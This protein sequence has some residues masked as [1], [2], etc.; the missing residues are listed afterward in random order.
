MQKPIAYANNTFSLEADSMAQI[1]K[2]QIAESTLAYI[3]PGAKCAKN[4]V[5][6]TFY[7]IQ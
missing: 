2:N 4:V 6:G 3:H 5:R 1:S 7:T